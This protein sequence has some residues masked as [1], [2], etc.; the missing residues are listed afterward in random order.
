[1]EVAIS[2]FNQVIVM[3]LLIAVGYACSRWNILSQDGAK[4][5][6]NLLIMVVIPIAIFSSFQRPFSKQLM[7]KL[8][9]GFVVAIAIHIIYII[10]A[11]MAFKQ[12]DK[13][14]YVVYRMSAIFSNSSFM[15][16][17]LIGA[18][19]GSEGVFIGSTYI[20]V[21]NVFL[22]T[23]G[24]YLITGDKSV[25]SLKKAFINPST[26][27]LLAGLVTFIFSI[28]LP[29]PLG[30]TVKYV[31][32]LNTPLA[33]LAMGIFVS[34][35]DIPSTLK[36]PVSYAVSALKLAVIPTALTLV[37]S[38]LPIDRT[39]LLT[40]LLSSS[41]PTAVSVMLF[42]AKFGGDYAESSGLIAKTTLL[43]ILTI[44][45]LVA[46]SQLIWN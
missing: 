36:K 30:T 15:A 12:D 33:M 40:L 45:L 26:L 9:W 27:A 16:L 2:I 8:G 38:M 10:A 3:F 18:V 1:M 5:I 32:S 22:W 7:M 29:G 11:T 23:Y 19:L 34:Q 21:M 41:C 25:I 37:F 28:S 4:Q 44:P 20:A 17:P 31:A 24:I 35:A 39:V 14:Q 13:R 42:S 46:L 43:S 6:S